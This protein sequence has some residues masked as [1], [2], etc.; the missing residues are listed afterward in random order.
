[1]SSTSHNGFAMSR[2][3]GY[4]VT[5]QKQNKWPWHLWLC[6]VR[7]HL[8]G[9]LK[10]LLTRIHLDRL[11]ERLNSRFGDKPQETMDKLHAR[12]Q[13]SF[14]DVD[15]YTDKIRM[16]VSRDTQAE[17]NIPNPMQLTL[18]IEGLLPQDAVNLKEPEILEE[19]MKAAKSFEYHEKIP[20]MQRKGR[21]AHQR[22]SNTNTRSQA[23][24]PVWQSQ[25]QKQDRMYHKIHTNAGAA[26]YQR[27][28]LGH[29]AD[30]TEDIPAAKA[31]TGSEGGACRPAPRELIFPALL[32]APCSF[33]SG[34][35]RARFKGFVCRP[36][37]GS[38]SPA[39]LKAPCTPKLRGIR[40]P[41]RN[42]N[43]RRCVPLCPA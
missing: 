7:P 32:K 6:V 38:C 31:Q 15:A 13:H 33:I 3:P 19:D 17:N 1:M 20:L 22:S 40:Q 35:R 10:P 12:Y 5:E 8:D 28:R 25:Q 18:S 29:R 16:L 30:K 27:I 39:L 9:L 14:E 4:V 21:S 26:T 36:V 24:P 42:S 37:H 11:K 34:A 2:S 43:A 23:L 41:E